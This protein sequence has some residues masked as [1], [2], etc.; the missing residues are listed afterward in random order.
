M[1]YCFFIVLLVVAQAHAD[2]LFIYDSVI[3]SVTS[4]YS[5]KDTT[6]DKAHFLKIS[7][8]Q[9]LQNAT[10]AYKAEGLMSAPAFFLQ[11]VPSSPKIVVGEGCGEN[12]MSWLKS[13]KILGHLKTKDSAMYIQVASQAVSI[14]KTSIKCPAGDRFTASP[15]QFSI[16]DNSFTILVCSDELNNNLLVVKTKSIE[17]D[18]KITDNCP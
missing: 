1:K 12:P 9:H 15:L 3:Y 11:K 5:P 10:F 17:A 16:G 13:A 2:F 6:V 7:V 18:L 8:K 14:G 4:K